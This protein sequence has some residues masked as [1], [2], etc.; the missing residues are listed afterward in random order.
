MKFSEVYSQKVD[1]FWKLGKCVKTILGEQ[2]CHSWKKY[3]GKCHVLYRDFEDIQNIPTVLLDRSYW[4]FRVLIGGV[5]V[6]LGDDDGYRFENAT[7][8]GT[9][10]IHQKISRKEMIW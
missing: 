1:S 8:Y 2:V 7:L 6:P 9:L 10:S 5:P 4:P 3:A